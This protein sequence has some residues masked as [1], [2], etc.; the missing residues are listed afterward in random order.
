MAIRTWVEIAEAAGF[1]CRQL[2]AIDVF[3]L[4][5]KIM[6]DPVVHERRLAA[7][8]GAFIGDVATAVNSLTPIEKVELRKRITT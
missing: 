3:E 4:G 8:N 7:R 5:G 1:D 2:T 6:R